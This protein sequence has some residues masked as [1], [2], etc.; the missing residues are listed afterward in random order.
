M[1]TEDAATCW[2]NQICKSTIG[3]VKL[4][5]DKV[6]TFLGREGRNKLLFTTT[7][8]KSA[9]PM[10]EKKYGKEHEMSLELSASN[11]TVQF[12]KFDS[13]LTVDFK[14]H[15]NVGVPDT[16]FI[17]TFDC[18]LSA[19]IIADNDVVYFKILDLKLG[20]LPTNKRKAEKDLMELSEN[21]YVAFRDALHFS[22]G[23]LRKLLNAEY[24]KQGIQLPYNIQE[25]NTSV[26]FKERAM[27][28]LME[29][30]RG[31]DRFFEDEFW[32]EDALRS[33]DY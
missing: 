10:L 13:D 21:E 9:F 18:I 17:D 6:N 25:I 12:G 1:F 5:Q 33:R 11:A 14:L 32:D 15:M 8:L 31:I 24:F 20:P 2:I 4:D 7:T 22:L 23:D 3:T 16:V 26:L 27:Y 30:E 28:V 19:D 29:I